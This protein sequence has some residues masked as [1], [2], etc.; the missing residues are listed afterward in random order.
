MVELSIQCALLF[1]C[2]FA[3]GD[4]DVNA[5]RPLRRAVT[6]IRHKHPR[7]DPA[8]FVSW[9]NHSV[10]PTVRR[11]PPAKGATPKS[12]PSHAVLRVHTCLPFAARNFGDSIWEAVDGSV[13]R[14]NL[15]PLRVDII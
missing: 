6:R 10:L 11:P 12:F 5:Y 3:R 7:L 8:N 9:A 4:I 14:G 13:T 15:Q 1:I 2:A